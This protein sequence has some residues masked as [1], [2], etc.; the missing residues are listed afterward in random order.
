M[1]G[2]AGEFDLGALFRAVDAE[3]QHRGSSWAALSK[4]V[5]VSTSTI[6]RFA[7]ADDAEAD[8]VLALVRWLDAAP[9]DYMPASPV[10][11]QRLPK[12]PSRYV[13]VD[14]EAVTEVWGTSTGTRTRTTIQRLVGTA[15][16]AG[17][18][19]AS[20]TRLSEV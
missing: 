20:L 6:R 11:G 4:E 14:M 1:T 19:V 8:G 16:H 13:R 18:P 2:P 7:E 17:R 10:R 12:N 5:G 3:R 15:Q 9:E